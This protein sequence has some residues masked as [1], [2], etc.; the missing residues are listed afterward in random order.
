MTVRWRGQDFDTV[1]Q[2]R[3]YWKNASMGDLVYIMDTNLQQRID[4]IGVATRYVEPNSSVLDVGCGTGIM[5][6]TLP[7][8]TDYYGIDLNEEYLNDARKNYPDYRFESRDFYDVIEEGKQYDYVVITS[9]FGLFPEEES[10]RLMAEAWKLCKKGM[11]LTTLNKDKY[12]LAPGRSRAK[13]TLTSHQPDELRSFL[14]DLP[15]V[16]KI[17]VDDRVPD[18]SKQS[19]KMVA[20]AWKE[21]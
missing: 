14:N 5:V 20:Y 6:H 12:R 15:L 10:Y 13:N 1:E 19:M 4:W 9:F 11:F 2:A 3:E 21:Q 18:G 7:E 8:N 16:T 17:I